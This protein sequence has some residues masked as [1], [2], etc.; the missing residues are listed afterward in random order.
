[1]GFELYSINII[2][3]HFQGFF[4]EGARWDR[5][6]H[7]LAEMSSKQ[8]HD[9]LPIILF[10]P[11]VYHDMPQSQGRGS[12]DEM[13]YECPVYRT[14]ERGG[15]L[16]TTGHSSNYILD[17]MLPSRHPTHHW[18]CRGAAALTQLDD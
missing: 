4:L 9:Q 13:N 1:M 17:L 11:A 12:E 16:S 5:E 14:S 6:R 2:Y 7:C 8:L 18:V 15:T 3:G 10:Q